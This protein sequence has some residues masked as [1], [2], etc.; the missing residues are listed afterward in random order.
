M[1][2]DYLIGV[3]VGTSGC[4]VAVF[5]R[6]FELQTISHREYTVFSG[7]PGWVE[8]DTE[9]VWKA[10]CESLREVA[11]EVDLHNARCHLTFSTVGEGLIIC[12]RSGNSLYP[13]II[14]SDVRSFENV[15]SITHNFDESELYRITGRFPHPMAVLPKILWVKEN[16]SFASRD[17]SFLDFQSWLQRKLG[18]NPLTDFS[19]AGGSM[20][21]DIDKK[22]WSEELLDFASVKTEQL[23]DTAPAGTKVGH[24]DYE[25]RA[26]IGFQDCDRV[27]V[28]LGSMDQMCNALG[29]GVVEYGDS[30]CSIGTVMCM[31]VVLDRT[32]DTDMLRKLRVPKVGSSIEDQYV[33]HILLWNGGGSLRWFRDNLAASVK[34]EAQKRDTDVYERLLGSESKK[35]TV[36]FLPHLTGSGTP[37]M[38][39]KSRGAFVGLT[40]ASDSRSMA[41]AVLEGVTFDLKLSIEKLETAGLIIKEIKAV[42]GGS[43]SPLWLQ[44]IADILDSRV[45]KPVLN[46]AGCAGA[47]I[48]SGFGAGFYPDLKETSRR[49]VKFEESFLPTE[50]TA[51]YAEKYQIYKD[52]YTT[53]KQLNHRICEIEAGDQK[54]KKNREVFL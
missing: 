28:Y 1:T 5:N 43:H 2:H 42:G 21:F 9:K 44:L 45:S 19:T 39:P 53:L 24:L 49:F 34:E 36:F 37:W 23:P 51:F 54:Q 30:V 35:N 18:F 32:T 8:L 6:E 52:I 11:I 17:I 10:I 22:R 7:K 27:N 29:S 40:L 47:A 25:S 15:N 31:T 14:S 4:K 38:D 13:A 20:M 3:D 46:E 50:K 48:L 33:T 16:Q 26:A 41:N 12:D